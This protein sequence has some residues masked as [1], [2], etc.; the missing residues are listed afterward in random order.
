L[1]KTGLRK[2]SPILVVFSSLEIIVTRRELL[3]IVES[4]K[5]FHYYLYCRKFLVRTDHALLKWLLSFED[6]EGQLARWMEKL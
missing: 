6:V 4:I 1:S 5:A 2:S 3:F